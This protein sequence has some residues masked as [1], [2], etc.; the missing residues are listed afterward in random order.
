MKE[1]VS[2]QEYMPYMSTLKKMNFNIRSDHFYEQ[3]GEQMQ[4]SYSTAKSIIEDILENFTNLKELKID[5]LGNY[6]R[7][8]KNRREIRQKFDRN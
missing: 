5:F 2:N 1:L 6:I 8:S 7:Q 3:S 4:M